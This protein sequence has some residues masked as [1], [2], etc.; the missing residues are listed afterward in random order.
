MDSI[1]QRVTNVTQ[2]TGQ[3]LD[4]S[5]EY[6]GNPKKTPRFIKQ[7]I[8]PYAIWGHPDLCPNNEKLYSFHS[9]LGRI[10][11]S[12]TFGGPG[13]KYKNINEDSFFFGTNV[14]D[15]L[16][17]GVVDG[18]GGSRFGY[19][20]GR[21]ANE[22]LAGEI[23]GGKNIKSAF[24]TA[25][26]QVASLAKGGYATGVAVEVDP[27]RLVTLAAKGDSRA[28]TVRDGKILTE[29]TSVMQSQVAMMIAHGELPPHA[30]HTARNK[31]VVYS[32]IGNPELPLFHRRFQALSGDSI[33]LA[34]DGLWDVVSDYEISMLA[35]EVHGWQLQQLLYQLAY[36][37][38]NSATP[39]TI[40]FA[41][42][43]FYP[44]SALHQGPH[45]TKGDNITVSVIEIE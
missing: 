37:R 7:V 23:F 39:F 38:N 32:V 16:V 1:I 20:G 19:L 6:S 21:I 8:S 17:A 44:M 45:H 41:E 14:R 33:I 28:V 26:Q 25:D 22:T 10:T 43:E 30:I 27:S 11:G 42:N 13:S 18:S 15:G 3:N 24:L 4:T 9:P 29:G 40:Q 5:F 34:S 31:N 36:R 12:T 2:F 35:A